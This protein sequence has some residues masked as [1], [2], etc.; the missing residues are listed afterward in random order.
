M[1]SMILMI[2]VIVKRSLTSLDDFA[3]QPRYLTLMNE[4]VVECGGPSLHA[5]SPFVA[6]EPHLLQDFG[7]K[8]LVV[9][10]NHT[11]GI[12]NPSS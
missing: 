12:A 9:G 2:S 7:D 6:V 1:I 4:R 10:G 5:R 3:A 8:V 11:A